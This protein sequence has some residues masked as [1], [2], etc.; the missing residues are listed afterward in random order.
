[1]RLLPPV[2][3]QTRG[4]TAPSILPTG[5]GPDGTHPISANAGDTIAINFFTLHRDAEIF[6]PDP[7]AFRPERWND[8]RP[9]WNFLPFGGG[10]RHCPAQQLA[11]F[12]VA[13]TL[14][15]MLLRYE[16]IRNEDPVEEF[17]ENMKL[18]MESANGA[19]VSFVS[20]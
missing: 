11:L 18:N 17:V 7:E 5:G 10:A 14:V 1:M 6:G 15:R 16:E 8:A 9:S 20:A 12:W 3:S 19:K 2:A 13:Y 4:C